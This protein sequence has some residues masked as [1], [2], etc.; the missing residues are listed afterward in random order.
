M[1]RFR[2]L[3][4]WALIAFAAAVL[5]GGLALATLYFVVSAKLP[6][7]QTLRHVEMQEPMYVYARDG[8]LL[9]LFGETRRYPIDIDEVPKRLKQAFLATE[10]ARFYEHH[11]VDYTGVARA[12]WL[13]IKTGS[14][15][16]VPGGRAA[17]HTSELT[18]LM[19]I[20]YAVFCLKNK[21]N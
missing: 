13:I 20:S 1:P 2:R 10:D 5:L 18:S 16:G 21:R 4:R 8:R 7:V 14:K 15:E 19:R 6:D 17:E 3:L 9:A 11:G 12:I